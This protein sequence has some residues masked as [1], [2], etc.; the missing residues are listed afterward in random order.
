MSRAGWMTGGLVA[1][2][3]MLGPSA[4]AGD[5]QVRFR[6]QEPFRVG[7][8]GYES[9]VI[10]LRSV[11]LY[12]PTT[13]ILEVWVDGECL[14]MMTAQRSNSEALPQHAEALFRRDDRGRLEM[15]GFTVPGR[16]TGTTFRF[17]V[18]PSVPAPEAITVAY[19][20]K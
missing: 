5:P 11:S 10:T 14:G 16:S 13:S 3:L 20:A 18:A 6:V 2:A 7:D 1:A 15:V 19:A 12:T 9:G 4:H 17:Q 8:R